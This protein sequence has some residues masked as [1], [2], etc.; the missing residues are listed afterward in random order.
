VIF[1][2]DGST[3]DSFDSRGT[4]S[5]LEEKQHEYNKDFSYESDAEAPTL[6]AARKPADI[7]DESEEEETPQADKDQEEATKLNPQHLNIKISATAQPMDERVELDELSLVFYNDPTETGLAPTPV[8]QD[9]VTSFTF[10]NIPKYMGVIASHETDIVTQ[11][12]FEFEKMNL[13]GDNVHEVPLMPMEPN[14]HNM[15]R[16]QLG[17]EF[18]HKLLINKRLAS[19]PRMYTTVLPPWRKEEPTTNTH[20]INFDLLVRKTGSL[21]ISA[22]KAEEN[23]EGVIFIGN[24]DSI[25]HAYLRPIARPYYFNWTRTQEATGRQGRAGDGPWLNYRLMSDPVLFRSVAFFNSNSVY[26]ENLPPGKYIVLLKTGDGFWGRSD[27]LTVYSNEHTSATVSLMKGHTLTVDVGRAVYDRF[28]GIPNTQVE[29]MHES[30]WFDAN[31]AFELV[32]E[33]GGPGTGVPTK[34]IKKQKTNPKG[35]AVFEPLE[36]GVY[37][38]IAKHPKHGEARAYHHVA[39]DNNTSETIYLGDG[40]GEVHFRVSNIDRL[41]LSKAELKYFRDGAPR[42]FRKQFQVPIKDELT[43]F[44]LPFGKWVVLWE[45][46]FAG[47]DPKGINSEWYSS[48]KLAHNNSEQINISESKIYEINATIPEQYATKLLL[49]KQNEP[50][51]KHRVWVRSMRG[52]FNLYANDYT[53]EDGEVYLDLTASK[54]ELKVYPERGTSIKIGEFEVSKN[55]DNEFIFEMTETTSFE[56]L[57]VDKETGE[58]IK[59]SFMIYNYEIVP[60]PR[61]EPF[62]R[63]LHFD[64]S[65]DGTFKVGEMK[66]AEYMFRF[67]IDG[68]ESLTQYVDFRNPDLRGIQHRFE[69]S[70]ISAKGIAHIYLKDHKGIPVRRAQLHRLMDEA[71]NIIVR[72]FI[73]SDEEGKFTIKNL[74]S[75]SY[76]ALI[77]SGWNSLFPSFISDPFVITEEEGIFEVH[78]TVDRAGEIEVFYEDESGNPISEVISRLLIKNDQFFEYTFLNN[79]TTYNFRETGGRNRAFWHHL[80][81]GEYRVI[82]EKEGYVQVG[83]PVRV[84]VIPDEMLSVTIQMRQQNR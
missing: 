36:A 34:G 72:Q 39:G 13:E 80:P 65:R 2:K 41:D 27:E 67:D 6:E 11:G 24:N 81:I 84:Q 1:K 35:R 69:F 14:Q 42:K 66:V 7:D 63:Q 17:E 74:K 64:N 19:F 38:I 58:P 52:A 76:V 79:V 61:Y 8:V 53:N 25:S 68:Y 77:E 54:Y 57:M 70:K 78:H 29:L 4:P 75:G 22:G 30:T 3:T 20:Q 46:K 40:D 73:T 44:S 26:W 59:G 62:M 33:A 9:V 12:Y 60:N 43:T 47:I 55:G 10:N 51:A 56:G 49:Y 16:Y 31:V 71:G 32:Y 21:E 37:D 48:P 28:S 23:S 18:N 15:H 50:L 5:K 82:G 45:F 83:D